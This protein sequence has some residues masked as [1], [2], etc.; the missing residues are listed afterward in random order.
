[1]AL[2]QLNGQARLSHAS[3][4]NDD[5]LVFSKKLHGKDNTVS[6]GDEGKFPIGSL[7]FEAIVVVF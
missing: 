3:T 7:T 2:D 6:N 4:S 5:Q 1:M